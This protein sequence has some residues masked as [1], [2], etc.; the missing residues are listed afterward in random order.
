MVLVD[1]LV[2]KDSLMDG[3]ALLDAMISSAPE[4]AYYGER[5]LQ[6]IAML[7]GTK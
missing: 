2:Q 7:R 1:V 3:L 6:I 5:K 4:V